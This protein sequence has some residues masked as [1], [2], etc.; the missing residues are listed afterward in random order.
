MSQGITVKA[1]LLAGATLTVLCISGPAISGVLD[2]AP[3]Y[4]PLPAYDWTGFYV[5]INGGGS[6]GRANWESDP[7]VTAGTVNRS[8]GLIGGTL[9]YNAQNLGRLVVGGEFDFNWRRFD[10]TIPAATCG[11]TCELDSNWFSTARI[12]F[13]YQ[14]GGL[15]PYVTGGMSMSD[16]TAY[17]AGQPNG[18]NRSVSFNFTAGAGV[19]FVLTGPLTGKL[20]YLYVNHDNIACVFECNGPVNITPNENI[21]RVGLNYRLWQ[22]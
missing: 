18:T 5:G 16:F 15:L 6:W 20:E 9:G 10:F 3:A 7:D 4:S 13:G 12:R 8:S 14:V 1:L 19:E 17:S 2:A 11:P 21:V 22:Q